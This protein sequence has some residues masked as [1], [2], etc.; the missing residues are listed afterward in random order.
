MT[1]TPLASDAQSLRD[2]ILTD[3]AVVL[4]DAQI[5]RALVEHE[6]AERGGNV[7]DMRGLAMSRLEQRLGQLEDT[8]QQV[9]SAAYDTVA[10]TAQ[11]HRAIAEMIAPLDFDGF[12][13]ALEG[14]VSECLRL[15]AVRIVVETADAQPDGLLDS[16]SS[17]VSLVPDGFV[18]G[19]AATGRGGVARPIVLRTV[20]RGS[21]AVYGT[22]A[23]DIRSEA[24]VRLDL[25]PGRATGLL[26]LGAETEDHFAPGQATDLL[27]FFSSIFLRLLRGWLG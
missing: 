25:G 14:G 15:R 26:V 5:L 23:A 13:A 12:L 6:Q 10:V 16:V 7:V 24:V 27:E 19:F 1:S 18:A 9:I 3:P 4:G 2:V 17:V 11:V 8:H 21:V 22:A 20:E